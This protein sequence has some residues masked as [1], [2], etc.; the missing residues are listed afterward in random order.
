MRSGF[1]II[2]TIGYIHEMQCFK[3]IKKKKKNTKQREMIK[4]RNSNKKSLAEVFARY[5]TIII[6]I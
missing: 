5:Q 6:K 1:D 4:V 3:T 2:A